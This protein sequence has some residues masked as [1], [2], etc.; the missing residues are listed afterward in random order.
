MTLIVTEYF[1]DKESS[2]SYSFDRALDSDRA[3]PKAS[4]PRVVRASRL[5]TRLFTLVA[6]LLRIGHVTTFTALYYLH[7][8]FHVSICNLTRLDHGL[9]AWT[10]L[11]RL[12][13]ASWAR[14]TFLHM[15]TNS[16]EQDTGAPSTH[17][18]V[19]EN[20]ELAVA[21]PALTFA[22]S[23]TGSLW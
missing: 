21:L 8:V 4:E 18:S 11:A 7:A 13:V 6:Q 23:S 14:S 17:Q 15:A 9:F 1:F 22:P 3:N 2:L 5:A 12:G 10:L 19:T 16:T 20:V